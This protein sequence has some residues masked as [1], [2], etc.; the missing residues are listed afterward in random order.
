MARLPS[1]T[2]KDQVPAA[3]HDVFDA[4][5]KSR[6]SVHGPFTMLMHCPPLAAHMVNIGGYVRF[7]GELDKRVRVLAAMTVAREFE[8]EYV[9]GAQTGSARKQGVPESTITAIREKHSRGVPAEDAQIID[10]TRDLIHKHRVSNE[11]MAAL[12]KRFGNFQLVELTGTIGYYA[13]LTFTA[14]ACE[15]EAGEGAEKLPR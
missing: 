11:A 4:V 9:W 10:F 5:A 13:M 8:A 6:G 3:Y 2:K 7:E 12:Q 1:I 15:L 14:N